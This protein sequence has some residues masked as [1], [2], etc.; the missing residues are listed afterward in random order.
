MLKGL[1]PPGHK[2][3][4]RE[5]SIWPNY[6]PITATLNPN[7]VEPKNQNPQALNL[8]LQSKALKR[9][10]IV[11]ESRESESTEAPQALNSQITKL[12]IEPSREVLEVS[13]DGLEQGCKACIPTFP[14]PLSLSRDFSLH[15]CVSLQFLSPSMTVLKA[16]KPYLTLMKPCK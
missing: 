11:P 6:V 7:N 5:T 16:I 15:R 12:A 2:T 13:A 4:L 1:A 9:N 14:L 10:P 3:I 8:K